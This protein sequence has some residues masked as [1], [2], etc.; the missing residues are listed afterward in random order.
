VKKILFLA[1]IFIILSCSNENSTAAE[2]VTDDIIVSNL[3]VWTDTKETALT[4][5]GKPNTTSQ[6]YNEID[7][8]NLTVW[9]YGKSELHFDKE[10]IYSFIINDESINLTKL[11][12]LNIGLSEERLELFI[13]KNNLEYIRG[14]NSIRFPIKDTI[15]YLTIRLLEEK[16]SEIS[17]WQDN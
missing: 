2:L 6:V 10:Y 13:K 3:Q 11:T 8:L 7:D 1:S 15:Y 14:S 4:T 5:L 9:T 16:I 17:I 12:L